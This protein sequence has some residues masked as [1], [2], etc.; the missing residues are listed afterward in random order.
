MLLLLVLF[1][2]GR[3]WDA[4][5]LVFLPWVI[6][7]DGI[8]LIGVAGL[9]FCF[10]FLGVFTFIFLCSYLPCDLSDF[11]AFMFFP[12]SCVVSGIIDSNAS[13]GGGSASLFGGGSASS[14]DGGIASSSSS[15]C[16]I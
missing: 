16:S 13:F 4:T 3:F 14:F 12:L 11:K 9:A 10:G 1:A 15:S 5:L 6:A 2:A 8:K 7:G